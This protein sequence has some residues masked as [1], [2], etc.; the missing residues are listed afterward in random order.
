MLSL[1]SDTW[2]ILE[3][4]QKY[5]SIFFFGLVTISIILELLGIGMVFPVIGLILN[6]NFLSSLPILNTSILKDID[7]YNLIS[8]SLLALFIIFLIK[9]TFMLF[10]YW[11]QNSFTTSTS[12]SLSKKLYSK[13]LYENYIFHVNTHSA[14]LIRNITSEVF[15]Y[16]Q[17]LLMLILLL[18]E[19]LIVISIF[20]LLLN[21]NFS[22]SIFAFVFLLFFLSIF[23]YFAKNVQKKWSVERQK[24]AEKTGKDLLEGLSSIKEIKIYR[25]EETFI[26]QFSNHNYLQ[27]NIFKKHGVLTESPRLLIEICSVGVLVLIL[28]ILSRGEYIEEQ[29]LSTVGIF[30]ASAFRMLPSLNRII[31]SIQN[32]RL[33]RSSI[34]VLLNELD[35]NKIEKKD[36]NKNHKYNLKNTFSINI[37]NLF[38]HY[39]DDKK[40][41][42]NNLNFKIKKGQCV[43]IIGE[44]GSG[45]STLVDIMLSLFTPSKGD[46]LFNDQSIFLNS[47]EWRKNI[48][49]VPQTTIL[50]DDTI[51]K[52]I[53]FG[54]KDDEIDK[55][56]ILECLKE[57]Q[58]DNFVNNLDHGINTYVGEKGI[59]ISGG[60]RQRI[61]IARALY[62]NP[63]I[64]IFDEATSSLDK[65]TEQK[66][67]ESIYK[68]K[69]NRTLIIVSHRLTSLNN[70]DLIYEIQKGKI[71]EVKYVNI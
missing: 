43:G 23:S 45:K 11:W 54:E 15:F 63:K 38:F 22:S 42:L 29:V 52:N 30:C 27:A 7:H 8:L 4:K 61:A 25:K 28:F 12:V 65:I 46:I 66:I 71:R 18:S 40:I 26:N 67:M 5:K 35:S 13:Y 64:L 37:E 62:N 32:I 70:C 2:K 34:P 39:N 19:I 33:Y 68:F 44:S 3:K 24:Y 9:N 49:Y 69:K 14:T 53:A 51:Q 60:Q 57:A 36:Y 21:I 58:L 48:G 56:R 59:K 1:L 6:P 17:L 16:Q 31:N 55:T 20:I 41:I 47:N 10:F 50:L